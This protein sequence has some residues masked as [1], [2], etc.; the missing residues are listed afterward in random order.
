MRGAG[1]GCVGLGLT[2]AGLL[3]L[4]RLPAVPVVPHPLLLLPLL[5]LQV[6]SP[7]RP[8][9]K[10]IESCENFDKMYTDLAP[11]V[12]SSTV[13]CCLPACPLT[14]PRDRATLGSRHLQL[15]V[16]WIRVWCPAT[17]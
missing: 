6:P 13:Q 14:S 3:G 10:S 11:T 15:L 5:P 2:A 9:I 8:T 16:F 4:L 17:H 1:W 12:R 7:F